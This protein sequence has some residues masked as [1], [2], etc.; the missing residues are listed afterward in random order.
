MMN[1][2]LSVIIPVH[3][4]SKKIKRTAKQILSQDYDNFELILVENGSTDLTW[5]ICKD[6]QA[7]DNRV[8]AIQ[9]EK[10]TTWARK[11]GIQHACG[12]YITF[13]DQDD[14]YIDN[15]AFN[16]MMTVAM[17]AS[18]DIIQFGHYVSRMGKLRE[19]KPPFSHE[20]NRDQL[21]KKDIG[22]VMGAYHY[23]ITAT[24]WDKLYK[25]II[26]KKAV[27]HVELRLCH[28]EDIF[29]NMFAFF[30]PST[31]A[32][33]YTSESVYIFNTGIGTSGAQNSGENLFKEY[34]LIKP[35]ALK[36]AYEN[37]VGEE[38]I[39]DCHLETVHFLYLLICDYIKS[40]K[41]REE[42]IE[43]MKEYFSW[44][45]VRQASEYFISSEGKKQWD[46]K[47]L[48]ISQIDDPEKYYEMCLRD[49]GNIPLARIKYITKWTA[50][51]IIRM[52]SN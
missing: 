12:E 35:V 32:I 51:N 13:S 16:S 39:R 23:P 25:A 11:A 2:K 9:S 34:K 26:L 5:D 38:P 43:K 45:F 37:R 18:S 15:H 3:N 4:G 50:K 10:G 33:R 36:M 30:D 22:G 1:P 49:I 42:I 6:I 29:L 27:Q 28:G 7:S 41:T 17:N 52:I 46:N 44:D 19:H 20:I 47:T 8:I 21:M 40:G 48:R 14:R 31:Q 24:V